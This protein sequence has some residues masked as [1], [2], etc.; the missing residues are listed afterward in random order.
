MADVE[1]SLRCKG[2]RDLLPQDMARF[3]RI[4][5]VLRNLCTLHGYS[6]VRTPTIEYLHLFTAAGTLSPRMLGRVYSF[7]DWDGWSG[8]RV[9]LRPDATIPTVRLY[10]EAFEPGQ[11][12][13]LLYITNVFRFTGGEESRE[14]WQ[15]G[16]E[17]IGD[18]AP[19]GDIELAY[20]AKRALE[21]L[22]LHDIEVRLSHAGLMRTI[23]GKS[24]L[25][26]E[27]QT[28]L[29]DRLLDGDRRV[30][31]ELEGRLPGLDRPLR[32]LFELEGTE[33]AFLTNLE[34]LF[35]SAMPE[36]R[37][38]LRELAPVAQALHALGCRLRLS[39]VLA[40][41]FE[42]YTGP[43]FQLYTG[44]TQV[45]GGGRYDGLVR[46]VGGHDVP[47]S[48]LAFDFDALAGLRAGEET[49]E[50]DRAVVVRATGTSAATL[51]AAFE[52]AHRFAEAGWRALVAPAPAWETM[53]RWE[54][55]I[56][57]RES[58]LAYLLQDRGAGS[59]TVHPGLEGALA[60]ATGGGGR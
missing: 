60:V 36:V 23:L 30:V 22:G 48:G 41:N 12:A 19:A 3:R 50:H 17:V 29:Y 8:E 32:L 6:E 25:P 16:L 4:E 13:K 1:T 18:T 5:Q 15:C 56:E 11:V 34:G 39:A 28:Q 55:T 26:L 46:L 9:V 59:W 47:A 24:G 49:P 10:T 35:A 2:M 14:D 53:P 27:E 21:Q 43:V 38:P 45:A 20:L 7:L 33:P 51:T 44:E 58:G 42:Y 52:A 40:R 31:D 37:Q 57:Q 54:L